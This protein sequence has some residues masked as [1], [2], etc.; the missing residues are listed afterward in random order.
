MQRFLAHQCSDTIGPWTV[1]HMDWSNFEWLKWVAN[2]PNL[3]LYLWSHSFLQPILDYAH[4]NNQDH[5]L[6]NL[7][8]P[9]LDLI[10][11]PS[12][13]KFYFELNEEMLKRPHS[14]PPRRSSR[15][16]FDATRNIRNMLETYYPEAPALIF[17]HNWN[18]ITHQNDPPT[19]LMMDPRTEDKPDRFDNASEDLIHEVFMYCYIPNLI[20]LWDWMF[21]TEEDADFVNSPN[22]E[23]ML[24]QYEQYADPEEH[25]ARSRYAQLTIARMGIHFYQLCFSKDWQYWDHP[26]NPCNVKKDNPFIPIAWKCSH[27]CSP[28]GNPLYSVPCSRFAQPNGTACKFHTLNPSPLRQLPRLKRAQPTEIAK[29]KYKKAHLKTDLVKYPKYPGSQRL[30]ARM[31]F[32]EGKNPPDGFYLPVLRYEG[33]YF[34]PD[35]YYCGKFFFYQPGSHIY[36]HLGNARFFASKVQAYFTLVNEVGPNASG[37]LLHSTVDENAL[38]DRAGVRQMETFHFNQYPYSEEL[39]LAIFESPNFKG[40]FSDYYSCSSEFF[41]PKVQDQYVRSRYFNVLLSEGDMP[42]DDPIMPILFP[43]VNP[44]NVTPVEVGEFDFLDQP[45]CNL[46]RELGID[47]IILQHEI[48]STDCVTEILDT[49]KDWKQHLYEIPNVLVFS[50]VKH[51]RF[52]KIWFPRDDGIVRVQTNRFQFANTV[53]YDVDNV[54]RHDVLRKIEPWTFRCKSV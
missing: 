30:V 16:L 26:D 39:L 19:D 35:P 40:Y 38:I 14:V 45:I 17:Q 52:P 22:I 1:T 33:L 9:W 42:L 15:N 54:F 4:R 23:Y 49:R 3:H 53:Q 2:E 34:A 25:N 24:D 10:F 7:L 43:S 50:D 51:T 28:S 6:F 27:T 47:T 37:V 48:G 11:L 41:I 46:A 29:T 12:E 13:C 32:A 21:D 44:K 31:D 8:Y 36:I 20:E 18:L 5:L